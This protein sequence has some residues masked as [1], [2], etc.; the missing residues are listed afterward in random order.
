MLEV[1]MSL[2]LAHVDVTIQQA[3]VAIELSGA[4]A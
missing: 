3:D 1:H 4:M 2:S